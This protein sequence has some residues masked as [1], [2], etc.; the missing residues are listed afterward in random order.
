M[1]DTR[2]GVLAKSI[3]AER[4]ESIALVQ[5][6][7][8]NISNIIVVL[9][10]LLTEIVARHLLVTPFKSYCTLQPARMTEILN[11]GRYSKDKV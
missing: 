5:V 7:I 2:S 6:F 9:I 8:V 3:F 1:D 11:S 10:F 4:I